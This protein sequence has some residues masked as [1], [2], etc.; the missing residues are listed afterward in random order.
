MATRNGAGGMWRVNPGG[1]GSDLG[2]AAS[3]GVF[4]RGCGK[5]RD[6][7]DELGGGRVWGDRGVSGNLIAGMWG[8][9]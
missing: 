5:M 6:S 2:R 7:V 8:N 9:G 4:H 3:G 1:M